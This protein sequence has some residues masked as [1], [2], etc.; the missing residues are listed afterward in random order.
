MNDAKVKGWNHFM[1]PEL[2]PKQISQFSGLNTSGGKKSQS[3]NTQY[4]VTTLIKTKST[5][6]ASQKQ[7]YCSTT[8][9]NTFITTD[10]TMSSKAVNTLKF[11]DLMVAMQP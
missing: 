6:S 3:I 5:A 1:M 4:F 2:T 9:T 10:N 11:K 8:C 7:M